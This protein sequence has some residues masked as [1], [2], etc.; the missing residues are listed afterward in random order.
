MKF[1]SLLKK[2]WPQLFLFILVTLLLSLNFTP[3]TYLLGW[4]NLAVEL[5]F[6][7]NLQ[8]A[9]NSSWQEYQGLGLLGGMGHAA[10]LLRQL[11][12]W[13]FTLVLK[14]NLLRYF[15]NYLSLLSGVWGAFT[16]FTYL[17]KNNKQARLLALLGASFYLLNLGT[18]QNFYVTFEPFAAFFAFFP[19]LIYYFLSYLERSNKKNLLGFIAFS[20]LG[21]IFGYVQTVFVVY[22]MILLTMLAFFLI[23][24]KVTWKKIW[25]IL[26]IVFLTNAFWLLPVVYFTLVASSTT[27]AAKTNLMSTEVTFLKN[28]QYGSFNN[29]VTLKGFWLDYTDFDRWGN[30]VYLMDMWKT[31]FNLLGIKILSWIYFVLVLLALV[32]MIVAKKSRSYLRQAHLAI[33]LVFFFSIFILAGSNPPLAFLYDFLRQ[34][35]PLFGQIF[36]SAFTK[37]VV[38]YSLFYALLII[39]ALAFLFSL[40]KKKI[41][42]YLLS[43]V[44]FLSLIVYSW[45][46]FTG[47]FFYSRLRVNIPDAYF[48]LFAYFKDEAPKNSRIA[49]FPQHSFYG[50]QW[51]DWGY[52]GSGFIWYGIKQPILDR[53]FDVWSEA[54]EGYYWQLQAALDKKDINALENVFAQYDV[55]YLLL[56][57]SIINRNTTKP[58]NYQAM[59]ELLLSSEQINLIKEFDFLSLYTFTE[60]EKLASKDFLTLYEDLPIIDNNYRFVWTDQAFADLQDYLTVI[61]IDKV[62]NQQNID[63]IYPF[64]ALFSNHLQE[65]LE[66]A[67]NEDENYFYLKSLKKHPGSDFQLYFA[68]LLNTEKQLPFRLTWQLTN[69][70]LSLNF[71]LLAPEI[72]DQGQIR[73]FFLEKEFDFDAL[74]CLASEACFININ[75]R[76]IDPLQESRELNFLL[77]TDLVNTI[78]LSTDLE[79]QYFDYAFFDLSLYRSEIVQSQL[80]NNEE[81]QVKIPKVLLQSDLMASELNQPEAK[82]CRP[83]QIGFVNKEFRSEGNFYQAISASACDHFYL[84]DLAHNSAYLIKIEANNLTSIPA[85]F[86]VQADSLGRSPIETYLSEGLNYQVL[87]P[88]E[89]FN[90]G[91]TLYFSTDSYG[92]E[93]NQNLIKSTEVYFWP[94]T[95]LKQLSWRNSVPIPKKQ[96]ADCNFTVKKRALWLY[97]LD[98]ASNCEA[99]Y[100]SLSQAYDR[101][102]LAYQDGQKLDHHQ[103]NNWA[104]V[105]ILNSFNEHARIWIV[106]WPQFLEHA[107]LLIIVLILIWLLIKNS[108][109]FKRFSKK[110]AI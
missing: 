11:L 84:P 19:W 83:L 62:A 71:K 87:P 57:E 66:F 109:R 88:V 104:N 35:V 31:H 103:L 54:N 94:Y 55:D 8:R 48:Q 75:N 42:Q 22:L 18:V 45:P 63:L 60:Q 23:K 74:A 76:L 43:I 67:L 105:W 26:L 91:Y 46:S 14:P 95:F 93:I 79:T 61:D 72:I 5:D 33:V 97:Q 78:A 41:F 77:N 30:S 82:N 13:P 65:N 24:K 101:G 47:N 38:P 4:D 99:K 59:K 80:E 92:R 89:D 73:S 16:L 39:F 56:D 1:I 2:I 51:H 3:D 25:T 28:N 40:I 52:R 27:L 68:D 37:W 7:L 20:L 85:V 44:F 50:W 49:N 58:F 102:W 64:P 53:A 6:P 9:F 10:D 32:S 12:L 100:L 69:N 36:R 110:R 86:A 106:F 34:Q 29:L 81:F 15:W 107:A 70:S 108:C 17:L 21:T 98:L 96:L 90:Q